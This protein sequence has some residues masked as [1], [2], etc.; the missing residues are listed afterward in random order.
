[1]TP[2]Q[3]KRKKDQLIREYGSQCWW[4]RHQLPAKSLTLDHIKPISKGGSS[5]L[6]NLR[7]ACRPCNQSRGNSLYPPEWLIPNFAL[8]HFSS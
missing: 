2:K 8:K 5:S 3:K 4:C 6:E 1:M 7:L